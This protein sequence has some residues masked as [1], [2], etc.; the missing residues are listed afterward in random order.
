MESFQDILR[1]GEKKDI[2]A[3]VREKNL[4]NPK[5]FDFNYIY[6]LL[7]D[8]REFFVNFITILRE[9]EIFDYN[10]WTFSFFHQYEEGIFELFRN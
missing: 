7:K 2:L 5:V 3:F 1:N 9:R 6:W 10:S 8:D 4:R